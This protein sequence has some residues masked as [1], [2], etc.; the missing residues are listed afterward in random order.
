MRHIMI[1]EPSSLFKNSYLWIKTIPTLL[2][3]LLYIMFR[4]HIIVLKCK[5]SY[6]SVNL[7]VLFPVHL[8]LLQW[9]HLTTSLYYIGGPTRPIAL[10]LCLTEYHWGPSQHHTLW[11]TPNFK[12]TD[13]I[14]CYGHSNNNSPERLQRFANHRRIW[15]SPG[16]RKMFV[17]FSLHGHI[18]Y[19]AGRRLLMITSADAR[20]GSVRCPPLKS[21]QFKF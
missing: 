8:L 4:K 15:E 20:L 16:H 21:R 11:N 6:K 2:V 13:P 17:I 12:L 14:V 9:V 3:W 1:K 19:G 18:S 10:T 5:M 7:L